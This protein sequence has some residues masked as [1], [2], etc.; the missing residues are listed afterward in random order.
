MNRTQPGL[1]ELYNISI[2]GNCYYR[3]NLKPDETIAYDSLRDGFFAYANSISIKNVSPKQVQNIFQSIKQD[4]P[5]LFFVESISYQYMA[6]VSSGTV[7][8]KYRFDVNK[9][10]STSM[11]LVKKCKDI[12]SRVNTINELLCET[13]IHD[14]LC[15]T[16]VYDYQFAESSFEVIGPMLFGKGVCEGISK[17]AKLLFDILGLK[18]LVIHGFS[19]QSQWQLGNDTGHAWNIFYLS[20]RPY[21]VD[22]TFDL[23]IASNGV[24]RYDYFNLSDEEIKYDH[25]LESHS[26][27]CQYSR[28]YYKENGLY[29]HNQASFS[30]YLKNTVPQK[31]DYVFRLP[32]TND[33]D[34]TKARVIKLFRDNMSKKVLFAL[35]FQL[36]Y[37]ESQCV[38]HFHIM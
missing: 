2:R 9:A 3:D 6:I 18:S 8:P 25:Q 12:L 19:L 26:P 15:R 37:N 24:I 20:G 22:I 36:S 31:K 11:I 16:V 5:G 14:Y 23:T 17:S 27:N 35:Q 32:K 7:I 33:F 28:D 30:E 1:N 4:N 34:R 38:F 29:F 21:H 10:E 13:N